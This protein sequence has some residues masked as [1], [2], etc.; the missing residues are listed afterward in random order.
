[1]GSGDLKIGDK[2]DNCRDRYGEMKFKACG[3]YR[4]GSSGPFAKSWVKEGHPGP[5][6]GERLSEQR[7]PSVGLLFQR[8]KPRSTQD[9]KV[10]RII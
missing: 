4:R 5:R 3:D 8:G 7:E 6:K 2:N 9:E 10:R 1:V